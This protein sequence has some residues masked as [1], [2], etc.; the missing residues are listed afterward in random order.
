MGRL[1]SGVKRAALI[2]CSVLLAIDAGAGL[3]EEVGRAIDE[4]GL[5]NA[6][7]S[8]RVE[9]EDGDVLYDRAGKIMVVP[10]SVR[11]MFTAWAVAECRG[12]DA[13]IE[14]E[15]VTDGAISGGILRG[16]LILRGSGDPSLGARYWQDRDLALIELLDS[17]R[18][19]GVREITGSV[20]ADGS[21]FDQL[22][23]PI[24][25]KASNLGESYAPPIEALAFNENVAGV[26][27]RSGDCRESLVWTDPEFVRV[28]DNTRCGAGT[29][30]V[31]F[32]AG[33][34]LQIDGSTIQLTRERTLLPSVENASL[35]AAQAVD[36]YLRRNAIDVKGSPGVTMEPIEGQTIHVF[37]S[38]TI[39]TLLGTMLEDSSN[40]F[41]EM[42]L[43]GLATD[44][45]A[46][47]E[48]ALEVERRIHETSAF[49]EPD[50][51]S[52][53]DGSGLSV[54]DWVE[55]ISIVRLVRAMYESDE[56]EVWR[57]L[58]ASPG[59]GTMRKRLTDLEGRVWGK[60][61]SLNGVRALAGWLEAD[62]GEVRFFSVI[63]NHAVPSWKATDAIN[64]IVRAIA[65]N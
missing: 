62:S 28:R 25:W 63:A 8:V 54:E 64:Q 58:L 14:T 18:E 24:G 33:N 44:F 5:Q 34:A 10:A 20:I 51:F 47:Y 48:S 43:K 6:L 46:S 30:E 36:D 60:T 53:T 16:N 40:L 4:A 23:F 2:G 7:W 37:E 15:V 39:H 42:L 29:L 45:P 21:R 19:R 61:G 41:A 57:E 12:L 26:F 49:V 9:S 32:I 11:K 35:Y 56:R 3:R 1:E 50:S 27:V 65:R 22:R 31:D 55:G 52:F 13:T 59:E 38:P 17:L